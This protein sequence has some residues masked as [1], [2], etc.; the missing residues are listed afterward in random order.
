MPRRGASK[1]YPKHTCMFVWRTRANYPRIIFKY[2]LL[3]SLAMTD[4]NLYWLPVPIV[5][6][7][8][9]HGEITSTARKQKGILSLVKNTHTHLKLAQALT[10]IFMRPSQGGT[11]SLVPLK[12]KIRIFPCSPKSNLDFLC[13]LFPKIA[14]VPQFPSVLDFRSLVPTI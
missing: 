14:F 3:P 6:V 8:T 9:R 12:K 5:K 10:A 13:S 2:S 4:L 7:D 1:E 11:C